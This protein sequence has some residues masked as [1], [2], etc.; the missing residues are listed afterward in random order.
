MAVDKKKAVLV[1]VCVVEFIILAAST[2]GNQWSKSILGDSGLF[3][4]CSSGNCYTYSSDDVSGE[5]RATQAFM[6]LSVLTT[7]VACVLSIYHY[8]KDKI[9]VKII[10]LVMVIAFVLA[11]IGLSVYTDNNSGADFGWS[12]ALGW[13]G[14]IGALVAGVVA[15]ISNR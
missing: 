9:Q 10:A 1:I 7:I 5:L 14:A 3:R 15:F 6:V 4:S 13:V 11:L 8:L 12:Y 2:G